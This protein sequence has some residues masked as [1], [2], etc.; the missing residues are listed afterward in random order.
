MSKKFTFSDLD[1]SLNLDMSGNIKVLYDGDTVKQSLRNI[2]ATISGERVRN[3][4]GSALVKLL[5]EPMNGDTVEAIQNVVNT[6]IVRYEPRVEIIDIHVIPHYDDGYYEVRV[7][8]YVRKLNDAVVF[9]T[10]LRSMYS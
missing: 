3:P 8:C 1:S 7:E 10:K 5:F 4:I 2:F 6:S 9:Q